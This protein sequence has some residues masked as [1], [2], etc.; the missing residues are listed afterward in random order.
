MSGGSQE[1]HSSSQGSQ[2]S[3]LP[4]TESEGDEDPLISTPHALTAHIKAT[5]TCM[6][7]EKGTSYTRVY[8][9]V[10]VRCAAHLC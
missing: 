2:G 4:P 8:T 7:T 9:C 10:M 5:C 6:W 1:S 3:T